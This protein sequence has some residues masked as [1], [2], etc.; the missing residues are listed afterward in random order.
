MISPTQVHIYILHT[1]TH[2]STHTSKRSQKPACRR[3][4]YEC[5]AN[6]NTKHDHEL[7]GCAKQRKICHYLLEFSLQVLYLVHDRART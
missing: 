7:R 6:S 1:H 2:K 4:E 5:K 3:S